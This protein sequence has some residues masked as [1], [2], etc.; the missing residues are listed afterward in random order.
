MEFVVAPMDRTAAEEIIGWRYD[1]PYSMY[2]GDTADVQAMLQPE[3][4]YQAVRDRDDRL[5]G[6][7]NFGD[8]ARV[9]GFAYSD[10][11]L[12]VGVGLR[13]DLTGHGL[14]I[15]FVRAALDFARREYGAQSLR[16]TV[17]AFNRRALRLTR[18]LGFG[19]VGRF[20][21]TDRRGA[22]T[23]FVVLLLSR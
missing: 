7:W 8:D 20:A 2:D 15:H 14:G 9:P 6:F 22:R 11:A 18:A 23:E 4:R 17:A 21:R 10:A 16:V 12:D 3:Y 5:V 13:P 19:E 1:A